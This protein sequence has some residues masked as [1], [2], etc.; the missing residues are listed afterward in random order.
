MLNIILTDIGT[1]QYRVATGRS[2]DEDVQSNTVPEFDYADISDSEADVY[3]DY[4]NEGLE[5]PVETSDDDVLEHIDVDDGTAIIE[6][7]MEVFDAK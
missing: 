4:N 1:V 3:G 7:L 2:I 6:K 5:D